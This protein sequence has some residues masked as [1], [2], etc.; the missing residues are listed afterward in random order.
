MCYTYLITN[1]IGL[2]CIEHKQILIYSFWAIFCNIFYLMIYWHLVVRQLYKISVKLYWRDYRLK[3]G[4]NIWRHEIIYDILA[5]IFIQIKWKFFQVKFHSISKKNVALN[6]YWN[7]SLLKNCWL[8]YTLAYMILEMTLSPQ[9]NN[10]HT[11]ERIK[12]LLLRKWFRYHYW[13]LDN[14]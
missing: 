13:L 10:V 1:S 3:V 14:H 12:F 5:S 11:P 7:S 2:F 6:Y 8:Y 9:V 4:F